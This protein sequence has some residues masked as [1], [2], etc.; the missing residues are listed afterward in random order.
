VARAGFIL[1]QNRFEIAGWPVCSVAA[2]WM[3]P[4]PRPH[5]ATDP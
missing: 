3:M 1:S 4:V 5:C 2:A